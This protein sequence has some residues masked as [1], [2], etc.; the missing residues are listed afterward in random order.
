MQTSIFAFGALVAGLG[1][2][3]F[4]MGQM[5]LGVSSMMTLW[6]TLGLSIGGF[7]AFLTGPVGLTVALGLATVA[8]YEFLG[9]KEGLEA[10]NVANI[11]AGVMVGGEGMVTV[12]T[13]AAGITE[14]YNSQ[15]AELYQHLGIVTTAAAEHRGRHGQR[16]RG[17]EACTQKPPAPPP[18]P[19]DSPPN[20]RSSTRTRRIKLRRTCARSTTTGA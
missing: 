2:A 8:I 11:N 9:A 12:L 15:L 17:T 16:R 20:R 7:V 18:K 6:G 13:E 3:I 1:P 14:D 5:A 19:S 10:S 4:L